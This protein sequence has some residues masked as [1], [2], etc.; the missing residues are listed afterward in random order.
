MAELKNSDESLISA[1]RSRN[2]EG[3]SDLEVTNTDWCQTER[4]RNR[5]QDINQSRRTPLPDENPATSSRSVLPSDTAVVN[6]CNSAIGCEQS[7]ARSAA[8]SIK[9]ML[10]LSF[11]HCRVPR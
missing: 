11:L 6:G 8:I 5:Q 4:N 1:E 2:Y 3:V 7:Q 9:T 10:L